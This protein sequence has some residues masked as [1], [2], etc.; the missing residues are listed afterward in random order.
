MEIFGSE[1]W[2]II[3]KNNIATAKQL[4]VR[5]GLKW[6]VKNTFEISKR[7][8]TMFRFL[9]SSAYFK[10]VYQNKLFLSL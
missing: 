6:Q 9:C 5:T 7:M 10:S 2:F 8:K 3:E 4:L 1:K